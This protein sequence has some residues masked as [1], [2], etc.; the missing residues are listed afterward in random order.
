MDEYERI[1]AKGGIVI[2]N[3]FD[4]FFIFKLIYFF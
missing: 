2:E 4:D 3:K 1:V